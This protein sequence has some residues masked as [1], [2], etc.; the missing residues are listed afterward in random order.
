MEDSAMLLLGHHLACFH[1]HGVE[2]AFCHC[3]LWAGCKL[4]RGNR[5]KL[6]WLEPDRIYQQAAIINE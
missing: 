6:L 1:G 3:T 5:L 4:P 2:M